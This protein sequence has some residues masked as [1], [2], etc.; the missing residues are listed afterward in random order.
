MKM[1]TVRS[2]S[3]GL[4]QRTFLTP[5]ERTLLSEGKVTVS[6]GSAL[7]TSA[8]VLSEAEKVRVKNLVEKVSGKKFS[9][10]YQVDRGLLG[11]LRIEL[12]DL[13]IDTS[14]KNAL[15]ELTGLLKS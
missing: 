7:V 10:R 2:R 4:K 11:G 12:G 13:I 14:L 3:S 6:G 5:K 8:I 1:Q 15:L 9:Y